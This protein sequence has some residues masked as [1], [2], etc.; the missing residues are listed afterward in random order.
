MCD[1]CLGLVEESNRIAELFY[2]DANN[3]LDLALKNIANLFM[4]DL[5]TD[6][7]WYLLQKYDKDRW[8]KE[9]EESFE[10]FR[11]ANNIS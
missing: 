10:K 7:K 1:H 3:N 4:G 9:T 2:S 8:F 5:H 11:K 6:Y